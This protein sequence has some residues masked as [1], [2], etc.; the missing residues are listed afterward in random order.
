MR[1]REATVSFRWRRGRASA[2]DRAGG[3]TSEFRW[4]GVGSRRSYA[5]RGEVVGE[6]TE[7]LVRGQGAH[8]AEAAA[9]ETEHGVRAVFGGRHDVHR[10]GESEVEGGVASPSRVGR[11]EGDLRRRCMKIAGAGGPIV[12]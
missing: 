6:Q 8:R 2:L 9:V 4:V 10:V 1:D 11:C 5:F 12:R 7:R 3:A